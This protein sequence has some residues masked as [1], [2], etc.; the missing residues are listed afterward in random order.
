MGDF[1]IYYTIL[2]RF[3]QENL[4]KKSE[5]KIWAREFCLPTG[6]KMVA[7]RGERP[8]VASVGSRETN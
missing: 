5:G 2:S 4:A 8:P 6:G 7:T 1:R 3:C